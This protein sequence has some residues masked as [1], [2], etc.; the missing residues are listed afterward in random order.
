MGILNL[1]PDSFYDGGRYSTVSAAVKRA[2]AMVAEGAEII[3][4][5]GESTRANFTAIDVETEWSRISEVLIEIAKLGV[6][7]SIDT[8]KPRVAELALEHG[9]SVI[10][11]VYA[12][13][14]LDE[15]IELAKTYGAELIAMHNA[16]SGPPPRDIIEDISASFQLAVDSAKEH[17]FDSKNLILDVGIGFGTTP[18]QGVEIISRLGKFTDKFHERVLIGASRKSFMEV[19]GESTPIDRLPCTIAS[20]IFAYLNGCSIFRVHDVKANFDALNFAKILYGK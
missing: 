20:T 19:L 17:K 18:M 9:A 10:N 13:E 1:T 8:R 2:E 6:K 5:G 7:V 12:F 11:D 3:D 15:I 14:H 16:R 4:V